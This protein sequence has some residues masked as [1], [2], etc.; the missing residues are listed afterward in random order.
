VIGALEIV[1]GLVLVG[2]TLA[3]LVGTLVL[4]RRSGRS[5]AEL[6]YLSGS[7]DAQKRRPRIAASRLATAVWRLSRLGFAA[8]DSLACRIYRATRRSRRLP[9]EPEGVNELRHRVL[10]PLGPLSLLF[11]FG[12]WLAAFWI[13]FALI[14][15][16]ILG[17]FGAALELSASSV[18][19]LGFASPATTAATVVVSFEGVIGILA[20]ALGISY[21]FTLYGHYNRREQ[22]MRVLE[23]RAGY[24]A[25]G[26]ELL[27][28]EADIGALGSL[29]G[30]YAEWESWAADVTEAQLAYPW[31]LLFRSADA[32]QSWVVSLLA[33]LDSAALY[34]ALAPEGEFAAEADHC[35]R[36]GFTAFREIALVLGIRVD[37]DPRP[38]AELR[39]PRAEFEREVAEILAKGFPATRPPDEAWP[40]FRGW[41]VNYEALAYDLVRDLAA[42]PAKWTG[43]SDPIET[44]RP[45]HRKPAPQLV[46]SPEQ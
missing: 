27:W 23:G 7:E 46:V 25:F 11:L 22:F 16:P 19:T 39:L 38:E 1:A 3:S 37:F 6:E 15:W 44:R 18:I 33:V 40:H 24:P 8:A 13:G 14:L 2:G 35:L 45:E 9:I 31:L 41:R 12:V 34:H 28:R 4:P 43:A 10:G 30:F 29:G 20:V 26:P 5:A 32:M 36:M 17:G 21:L 42:V